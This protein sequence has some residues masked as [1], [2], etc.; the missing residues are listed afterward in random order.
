MRISP[1]GLLTL[2]LAASL[3]VAP[4]QAAD[5]QWLSIG[6]VLD[7]SV[8]KMIYIDSTSI[9]LDG[10]FKKAMGVDVIESDGGL[11]DSIYIVTASQFDCKTARSRQIRREFY[12]DDDRLIAAETK[13][14][15]SISVADDAATLARFYVVCRAG[16]PNSYGVDNPVDAAHAYFLKYRAERRR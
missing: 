16:V 4:A 14:G 2:L 5:H 11:L 15:S 12:D 8:R 9:A 3:I 7:A 1:R 13:Q 6:V 10:T